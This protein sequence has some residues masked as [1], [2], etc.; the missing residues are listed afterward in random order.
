MV[1]VTEMVVGKKYMVNGQAKHLFPKLYQVM[2]EAVVRNHII[3]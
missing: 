1:K 3:H 2:V